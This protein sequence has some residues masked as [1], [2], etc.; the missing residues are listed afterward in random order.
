MKTRLYMLAAAVLLSNAASAELLCVKKVMTVNKNKV[1][2]TSLYKT[3]AGTSC[4]KGFIEVL[5]T[6]VL[7]GPTGPTGP[8]GATGSA[9]RD[10]SP[11]DC[12]FEPGTCTDIA[13]T[14]GEVATMCPEGYFLLTHGSLGGTADTRINNI[15]L[16]QRGGKDY[17]T[18]VASGVRYAFS[19]AQPLGQMCVD[20]VCCPLPAGAN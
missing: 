12:L 6:D 8:T 20:A 11:L 16:L 1:N 13:G 9:G 2:N 19:A 10:F 17:D 4:P 3:V 14:S 5:D 7:V 18:K 15:Y